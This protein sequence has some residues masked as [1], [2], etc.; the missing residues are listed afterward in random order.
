MKAA[1]LVEAMTKKNEFQ[2]NINGDLG[3]VLRR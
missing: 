2:K 1:E 3:K